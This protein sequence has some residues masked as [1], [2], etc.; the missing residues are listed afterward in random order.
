MNPLNSHPRNEV[1]VV[2]YSCRVGSCWTPEDF[3]KKV[4]VGTDFVSSVPKQ[5][6]TEKPGSP[7]F[8]CFFD[9]LELF[10]AKFFNLLPGTARMWSPCRKMSLE[11]AWEAVESS[12][13]SI[14]EVMNSNFGCF[15]GLNESDYQIRAEEFGSAMAPNAL[16]H[17][18]ISYFFNLSGSAAAVS[19]ACSSSLLAIIIGSEEI[20]RHSMDACF[21]VGANAI[22]RPEYGI[23][24]RMEGLGSPSGRCRTFD[25]SADGYVWCEGCAVIL[26]SSRSNASCGPLLIGTGQSQDGRGPRRGV[27]VR[28]RQ[29][30]CFAKALRKACVQGSQILQ[31][32]AQGTG[33]VLADATEAESACETFGADR[34]IPLVMQ[35]LKTL[36]GH[37]EAASGAIGVVRTSLCLSNFLLPPHLHLQQLSSQISCKMLEKNRVCIPLEPVIVERGNNFIIGESHFGAGGTNAHIIF[38]ISSRIYTDEGIKISCVVLTAPSSSQLTTIMQDQAKYLCESGISSMYFDTLMKQRQKSDFFAIL[39]G[40]TT[41]ELRKHL[42]Q[43]PVAENS[44]VLFGRK[45]PRGASAIALCCKGLLQNRLSTEANALHEFSQVLECANVCRQLQFMGISFEYGWSSGRSAF[46]MGLAFCPEISPESCKEM[47]FSFK[48]NCEKF[49]FLRIF[50]GTKTVSP[51]ELEEKRKF[52]ENLPLKDAKKVLNDTKSFRK[53]GFFQSICSREQY[54]PQKVFKRSPSWIHFS[55]SVRLPTNIKLVIQVGGSAILRHDVSRKN[56]KI[57]VIDAPGRHGYCKGNFH[58]ALSLASVFCVVQESKEP[59][60]FDS[61]CPKFPFDRKNLYFPQQIDDRFGDLNN[62]NPQ[63]SKIEGESKTVKKLSQ[64]LEPVDVESSVRSILGLSKSDPLDLDTVFWDLGFTSRSAVLLANTLSSR[65]NKAVTATTIFNFPTVRL[66]QKNLQ[67]QKNDDDD[68]SFERLQIKTRRKHLRPVSLCGISCRFSALLNP[69]DLWNT[70]LEGNDEITVV[71]SSRWNWE[72]NSESVSKWGCFMK[73]IDKFD[74]AFFGISPRECIEMDPQQRLVLECGWECIENGG[75]DPLKLNNIFEEHVNTYV[76][77]QGNEYDY[78]LGGSIETF[79]ATGM[80]PSVAAGRLSYFLGL[81][82][83]AILIDTACSSSLVALSHGVEEIENGNSNASLVFGVNAMINPNMFVV[84]SKAGMFSPDGRCKTFDE[85]ANGYVRGE[86]C[87]GA[88]LKMTELKEDAWGLVKGHAVNQDGRSNGLTAPSGVAQQKL[89]RSVLFQTDLSGS[90]VSLIEAHGTGTSLGDPIEVEALSESTCLDRK[91]DAPHVIGSAKTNFGHTEAASGI[92]GTL[93]TVLCLD[94]G[95][96]A[97]HLHLRQLNQFIGKAKLESMISVIP[98]EGVSMLGH[99]IYASVSSFSMM[100]TNCNFIFGKSSPKI[101]HEQSAKTKLLRISGKSQRVLELLAEVYSDWIIESSPNRQL[102]TTFVGRSAFD[103]GTEFSFSENKNIVLSLK[104]KSSLRG[105]KFV[106]IT[107]DQ[108]EFNIRSLNCPTYVFDRQKHWPVSRA[109]VLLKG[110]D[111]GELRCS[112]CGSPIGLDESCAT[113]DGSCIHSSCKSDYDNSKKICPDCS[114]MIGHGKYLVFVDETFHEKCFNINHLCEFCHQGMTRT[115]A[116]IFNDKKVHAHCLTE[117]RKTFKK[118]CEGCGGQIFES[119]DIL[120]VNDKKIHSKCYL[121]YRN[122]ARVSPNHLGLAKFVQQNEKVEDVAGEDLGT[123]DHH[124]R[125]VVASSLNMNLNDVQSS[126]MLVDLGLDSM[127]GADLRSSFQKTT[128]VSLPPTFLF[129][130][131]TLGDISNFLTENGGKLKEQ[132][133]ESLSEQDEEIISILGRYP[134]LR[135]VIQI[136]MSLCILIFLIASIFPAVVFAGYVL[137]P[138]H[139]TLIPLALPVGCLTMMFYQVVLKWVIIGRYRPGKYPI[140]GGMFLRWWFVDRMTKTTLTVCLAGLTRDSCFAKLWYLVLG[141]KISWHCTLKSNIFEPDLITMR[142]GSGIESSLSAAIV[143][144][145]YL[146]LREVVLDEG[147]WVGVGSVVAPGSKVPRDCYLEDMSYLHENFKDDGIRGK[148]L[149]GSPATISEKNFNPN[150]KHD[151]IGWEVLKLLFKLVCPSYFFG[152]CVG[153]QVFLFNNIILPTYGIWIAVAFLVLLIPAIIP[154]GC[155]ALIIFKWLICFRVFP[156]E[157]SMNGFLAFRLELLDCLF[158]TPFRLVVGAWNYL[159]WLMWF[160]RFLGANIKRQSIMGYSPSFA[161]ASWDL[162]SIGTGTFVAPYVVFKTWKYEDSKMVL[163]KIVVGD[164]SSIGTG[165]VIQGG[166]FGKEKVGVS[167]LSLLPGNKTVE[168]GLYAGVP[169][170]T[171]SSRVVE[172]N[173][174]IKYTPWYD[175][176][177]STF[178]GM[179]FWIMIDG[180]CFA[181][182]TVWLY[183]RAFLLGYFNIQ[184]PSFVG[185][186]IVPFSGVALA[187][188]TFA[189]AYPFV[190]MIVYRLISTRAKLVNH[191]N[192]SVS[193]F[194]SLEFFLMLFFNPILGGSSYLNFIYRCWGGTIGKGCYIDSPFFSDVCLH[195]IG[196]HC[197]I[198]GLVDPHGPDGMRWA[199]RYGSF[200]M[201]KFSVLDRQAMVSMELSC[202]KHVTILPISRVLVGDLIQEGEIMVG[203][204]AK[205]WS[206]K[207]HQQDMQ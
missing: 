97:S 125:Q 192:W 185:S 16:G 182:F 1:Q 183:W 34:K 59:K 144:P 48:R 44:G 177:M 159:P 90:D 35:T 204:P 4:A 190:A 94:R 153:V 203:S 151:F 140:W 37:A 109:K 206:E 40:G 11:C 62:L 67:T 119:D 26:L 155:I 39:F 85:S 66:L 100:G 148:V 19:S 69:N 54:H 77:I 42:L 145:T 87:G 43:G 188:L 83:E 166:F 200:K 2:G 51:K 56:L 160:C 25:Q 65:T 112:F 111:S 30:A 14:S 132:E 110:S 170:K 70:F 207:M 104:N 82:G 187:I 13:F 120:F 49:L 20:E 116:V 172:M 45:N 101:M 142:P 154:C 9:G 41:K 64:I 18:D 58:L 80:A 74:G 193:L 129:E 68:S 103:F 118:I 38:S 158:Q 102:Q 12:C 133:N 165:C 36:V 164:D 181:G 162:I 88:F 194:N 176:I 78:L 24:L 171:L 163:S 149:V 55:D 173:G 161:L 156:G 126:C 174:H 89:L 72:E 93:K 137:I 22:N 186:T 157:Y 3:W 84:I 205:R 91:R 195:E 79:R 7:K 180:F 127:L 107:Q 53:A 123:I 73:D 122:L 201:G 99:D 198:Q 105:R 60:F 168:P 175:L 124:V 138:I 108:H 6:W 191:V 33:T 117:F 71:P 113:D 178:F 152:F 147:A 130:F 92:L 28:K 98:V 136:L 63:V 47:F 150:L 31:Y 189:A 143:R 115:E 169:L 146:E 141:G 15:Y 106:E 61:N 197:V 5:R 128:G 167:S 75:Y 131:E 8:G 27:P 96:A 86:G 134:V 57:Q 17:G 135:V 95:H 114:Q 139:F 179:I 46:G 81:T 50:S 52:F 21:C 32:E 10:D 121:S 184:I 196:D 199:M 29:I 23:I 76:G 202:E